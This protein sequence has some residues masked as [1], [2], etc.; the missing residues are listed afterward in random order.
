MN[1]LSSPMGYVL[2]FESLEDLKGT[3]ENLTGLKNYTEMQEI[4][5]PH[6]YACFDERIPKEEIEEMLDEIKKR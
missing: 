3:I 2:V 6:L 1:I 4:D 5:P